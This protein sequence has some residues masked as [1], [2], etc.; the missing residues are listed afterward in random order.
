MRKIPRFLLAF[1][2]LFVSFTAC[3]AVPS[4]SHVEPATRIP[5]IKL[6]NTA[7]HH[8][9]FVVGSVPALEKITAQKFWLSNS[10]EAWEMNTHPAPRKQYVITLQGTLKFRVS[11]GSTFLLSPGTILIADDTK[12]EGHSWE[13]VKG[14]KWVRVYIPVVGDDDHFIP[15]PQVINSTAAH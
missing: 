3:S 5:A 15:D 13:M 9:A 12:S 4:S 6:I 1:A 2:G 8:A 11:D 7:D 14:D 10:T